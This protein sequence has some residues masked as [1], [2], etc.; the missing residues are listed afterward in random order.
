MNITARKFIEGPRAAIAQWLAAHTPRLKGRAR[1]PGPTAGSD[2][3]V[4]DGCGL[5]L[6]ETDKEAVTIIKVAL[7]RGA[8]QFELARAAVAAAREVLPLVTKSKSEAIAVV[9]AVEALV[10][11]PSRQN[12]NLVSIAR[13]K[14]EADQE[15]RRGSMDI[16]MP[17]KFAFFAVLGASMA[18]NFLLCADQLAVVAVECACEAAGPENNIAAVVTAALL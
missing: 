16:D 7:H 10:S 1:A 14:L 12:A 8:S 4:H 11:N 2:E 9:E 6:R 18:S 5:D 17:E 15:E 3:R 13:S